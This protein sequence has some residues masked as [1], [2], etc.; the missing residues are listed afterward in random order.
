MFSTITC[1]FKDGSFT[2]NPSKTR[3][4]RTSIDQSRREYHLQQAKKQSEHDECHPSAGI[5][6]YSLLPII[7]IIKLY[8]TYA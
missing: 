3:D 1:M 4:E 8:N 7:T 6:T 2:R 5:Q